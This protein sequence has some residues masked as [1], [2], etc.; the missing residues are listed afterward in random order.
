MSTTISNIS[1]TT[2]T[3]AEMLSNVVSSITSKF[4][5]T[6][7]NYPPGVNGFVFDVIDDEEITLDADITDSF[8]ETGGNVQDHIVWRLH[9][10]AY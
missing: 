9:W 3:S 5:V 4:I 2:A 10:R 6:P 8:I 7:S 1:S